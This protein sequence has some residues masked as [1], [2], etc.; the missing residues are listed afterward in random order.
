MCRRS[1]LK[2]RLS[3][4]LK[5]RL[6]AQLFRIT[7]MFIGTRV[8]VIHCQ[9]YNRV[10]HANFFCQQKCQAYTPFGPFSRNGCEH[11]HSSRCGKIT[12]RILGRLTSDD[13]LFGDLT[14]SW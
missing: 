11:G 13:A 12:N 8:Q 1:Y 2:L 3:E 9:S 14:F 10:T 4:I 6:S 7:S 5:F